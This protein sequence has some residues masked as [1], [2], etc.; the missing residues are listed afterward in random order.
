[1]DFVEAPPR[2]KHADGENVAEGQ[3]SHGLCL[4]TGHGF[5]EIWLEELIISNL[6]LIKMML[7]GKSTMLS[8]CSM[9]RVFREI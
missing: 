8:V 3:L 2:F 9:G 1:V 6:L 5:R 4:F 7:N